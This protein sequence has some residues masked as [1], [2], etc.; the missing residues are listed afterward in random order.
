MKGY[1]LIIPV[2]IKSREFESRL[3]LAMEAMRNGYRVIFGDQT[4]IRR[5]I[6]HLPRGIYFDKSIAK[7]KLSFLRSL[8]DKGFL[9]TGIDE[10]GLSSNNNAWIYL[11]QRVSKKT[12]ELVSM[13]FTWGKDE[14]ELIY[15]NFPEVDKNKIVISGNPRVDIWKSDLKHIHREKALQYNEIYGDYILMPTSFGVV[16]AAGDKFL[17]Q[18]AKEYGIV[19]NNKDEAIFDSNLRFLEKTMDKFAELISKVAEAFP[20]TNIIVRPH[21]SEDKNYWKEATKSHENVYVIYEGSITPWILGSKLLIHSSCTTGL[22]AA[23]M[24]KFVITYIPYSDD[25]HVSHVSNKVSLKTSTMPEVIDEVRKS[26]HGFDSQNRVGL[27]H[28]K[29]QIASLGDEMAYEKIIHSIRSLPLNPDNVNFSLYKKAFLFFRFDVKRM[30]KRRL[31]KDMKYKKQKMPKIK[32]HEVVHLMKKYAELNDK[33]DFKQI[34]T[35]KLGNNLFL[36]Y[37]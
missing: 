16:H 25:E 17:K 23:L 11:K 24:R 15:N 31:L 35:Q 7:N 28:I 30:I 14:S 34:K 29:E 8:A 37:S 6:N 13:F 18:Q 20:D 26:L 1:W 33:F 27:E 10:E 32:Q 9:L 4:Q 36:I 21:P 22:E 12:L 5:Y 3:L 19:E 2:E